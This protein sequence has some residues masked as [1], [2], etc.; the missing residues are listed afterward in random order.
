MKKILKAFLY[1]LILGILALGGY[2]AYITYFKKTPKTEAFNFVPKET[3]FLMQT[4]NLT[5]AWTKLSNTPL[6]Q[7]LIKTNY[8]AEWNEDI[9]LV[10]AFLDSNKVAN[11]LLKNRSLIMAA[12]ID[13]TDW[14]FLYIVD[15]SSASQVFSDFNALLKYVEG[16][17]YTKEQIKINDQDY[18]L[19]ALQDLEYP[20]DILY[21]TVVNN[22]LLVSYT[23]NLIV[24][25]IR[26]KDDNHWQQ[27]PLFKQTLDYLAEDKLFKII[28]NYSVLDE[29]ANLY[30]TEKDP[31]IEML[32]QTLKYSVFNMDVQEDRVML[33]GVTTADTSGSYLKSLLNLPSGKLESYKI[34]TNQTALFFSLSFRDFQQFYNQMLDEYKQSD[35]ETAHEIEKGLNILKNTFKIDIEKDFISWIGSEIAVYKLQPLSKSSK[36]EDVVL[37]V[38]ANDI[39]AAKQ[40]LENIVNQIRKITPFK[41]KKFSY[42]GFEI[43]YLHYKKFFSL[44]F[45]KLFSKIDRPYYTFIEDYVVFSNSLEALELVIDDYLN[46]NTIPSNENFDDFLN[47]FYIKNNFGIFIQMPK[48]YPTLYYFTPREDR[49][50]LEENKD[51]ITSFSYIGFQLVTASGKLKSIFGIEYDPEAPVTEKTQLL[52]RQSEEGLLTEMLDTMGYKIELTAAEKQQ[53]GLYREYYD[54]DST[55][56]KIEGQ[57]SGG[58][59]TG[60]WRTYYPDGNLRGRITYVDGKVE[61]IGYF[62][63]DDNTNQLRAEISFE[64]DLPNGVY[65]EYYENGA[66]RAL[67]NYK[68]GKL[69]GDAEYYYKNGKLKIEGKYKD[70]KKHGKWAYY[71]ED[72]NLLKKEKWKNGVLK[73][74]KDILL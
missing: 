2:I 71:D 70:G 56:L 46:G 10:D 62:Y 39:D 55:I 18:E 63:F 41:F 68:D 17:K 51:L 36:L 54:A 19:V 4:R 3:F 74:E 21:M 25:A 5:E 38:E 44:F 16:Y 66:P 69:D 37:V 64:N 24:N 52:V 35:P 49:K 42:K 20:E 13:K 67:L 53:D 11:Y 15:L 12:V 28:V 58:V 1:L 47:T 33:E 65:K 32:S 30:L 29:F 40:G 45:G 7:K 48:L 23:K 9:E 6:W 22:V 60:E 31:M 34:M 8:F 73:R 57:I 59:Q 14:D 61:G 72:G 43:N 50:D 26:Q 27:D